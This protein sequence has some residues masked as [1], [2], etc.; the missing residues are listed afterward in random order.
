MSDGAQNNPVDTSVDISLDRFKRTNAAS[1]LDIH[2]TAV[3]DVFD[4]V[5]IFRQT[6]EGAVQVHHMNELSAL[7][8]P[9]FSHGLGIIRINGF[10]VLFAL[11]Q[12]DASTA[13]DIHCGNNFH[14]ANPS[15]ETSL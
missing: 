12:A 11:R 1:H 7:L 14:S 5:G 4:E 9:M 6:L 3:Y 10:L 8:I 13:F 15:L 2:G